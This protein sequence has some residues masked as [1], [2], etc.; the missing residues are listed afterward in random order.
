MKKIIL[1][2]TLLCLITGC[3]EKKEDTNTILNN[4]TDIIKEQTVNTFTMS[5]T[6]L[7][8]KDG[9]STLTVTVTNTSSEAITINQ[10]DVVFKTEN[11]SV[12]T[13]LNGSLGDQMESNSSLTITIT[14]DIDLSEAYSLEY[15]IS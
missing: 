3:G 6:S 1:I 9:I 12:I 4:N 2:I 10:F 7:S 11:G 15:Q 13:T 5:N 8:Y 14:S